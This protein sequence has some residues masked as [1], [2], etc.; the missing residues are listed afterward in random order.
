MPG[1]DSY[2]IVVSEYTSP[3]NSEVYRFALAAGTSMSSP[4][5]AGI[6]ALLLEQNPTLWPYQV[7]E[8][9]QNTAIVDDFTG[10]IPEEGD[11]GWGWGK[12]NAHAAM[13]YVLEGVGIYHDDAGLNL[14]LY[15]NP[16]KDVYNINYDSNSDEMLTINVVDINGKTV[17]THA[18]KVTTGANTRRFDMSGLPAGIYL[19]NLVG[20]SSAGTVKVVKG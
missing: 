19:V 9:L 10:P 1:G 13:L 17:E 2:N 6:I 8:V 12:A 11:Y 4:C 3:L 14:L 5:V 20:G 7:R 18:W 16:V 15:P